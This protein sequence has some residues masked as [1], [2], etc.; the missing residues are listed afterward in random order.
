M[1]L[2]VGPNHNG[3]DRVE[4]CFSMTNTF[5]NDF[6]FNPADDQKVVI[7]FGH[8]PFEGDFTIAPDC[9]DPGRF[10]F[11][12]GSLTSLVNP[13][14]VNFEASDDKDFEMA[15]KFSQ[16]VSLTTGQTLNF[17]CI[18]NVNIDCSCENLIAFIDCYG[19]QHVEF[20]N[21]NVI[22]SG[23]ENCEQIE[24]PEPIIEQE[25]ISIFCEQNDNERWIRWEIIENVE[26]YEIKVNDGFWQPTN[27]NDSHLISSQDSTNFYSIEV[28]A[29]TGC[30]PMPMGIVNCTFESEK[31]ELV[32]IPNAFSPNGD[33]IND[34]LIITSKPGVFLKELRIYERYGGL[35]YSVASLDNREVITWNVQNSNLN[36]SPQLFLCQVILVNRQGEEEVVYGDV[37]ILK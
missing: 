23:D 34:E 22:V 8:P 1:N 9:L 6:D 28:R 11:V 27:Q 30:E 35:V 20:Q 37:T 5:Q 18:Q 12:S 10:R 26:R 24:F 4:L 15:F 14:S 7:Q 21:G 36:Y 2:E 17:G 19:I 13:N 3:V 32:Y 31:E 16:R 33:G 29:L 25:E